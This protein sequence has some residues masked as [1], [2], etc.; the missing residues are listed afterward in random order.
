M[1]ALRKPPPP[2]DREV[3]AAMG[4]FWCV[5]EGALQSIRDE[6][7]CSFFICAALTLL[8]S[9]SVSKRR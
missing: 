5:V 9:L 6:R 4:A 1:L 2:G 8:L 7:L 3:R